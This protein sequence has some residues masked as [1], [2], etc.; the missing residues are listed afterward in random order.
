MHPNDAQLSRVSTREVG[1]T[2]EDLSFSI[3]KDFEIAVDAEAGDTIFNDGAQYH[4]DVVVIDYSQ[5][6][7][8]IPSITPVGSTTVGGV[9][10]AM[11]AAPWDT[12]AKQFAF[13]VHFADLAGRVDHMCQVYAFLRVGGG[14]EPNVSIE[15][16]PF[17]LLHA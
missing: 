2:V 5:N 15:T 10:S 9:A 8:N 14:A 6:A 12:Q 13:T 1:T 17:F 4:I 16:S 11:N 3:K 7:T